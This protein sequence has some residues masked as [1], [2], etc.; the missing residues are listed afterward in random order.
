[1]QKIMFRLPWHRGGCSRSHVQYC[2]AVNR[3]IDF[4]ACECNGFRV[5]LGVRN[6]G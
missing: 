4:G 6:I 5:V 2:C 1:M 3:N